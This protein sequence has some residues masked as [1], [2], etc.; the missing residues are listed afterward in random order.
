[1]LAVLLVLYRVQTEPA[2]TF[3][4]AI[5]APDDL[6][7]T[8]HLNIS[9][10]LPF[11]TAVI[12]HIDLFYSLNCGSADQLQRRLESVKFVYGDWELIPT[13]LQAENFRLLNLVNSS[14]NA[15]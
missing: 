9:T 8:S 10:L 7:A 11:S 1:M 4:A 13:T 5:K 2:P 3:D 14:R 12:L 15:H 6:Q